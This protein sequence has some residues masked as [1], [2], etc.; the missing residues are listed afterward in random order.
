MLS[1][2]NSGLV[3]GGDIYAVE[4]EVNAGYGELPRNLGDG[5]VGFLGKTN[6]LGF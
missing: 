5:L 3:S 6:C 2:V 4:I 1:Q